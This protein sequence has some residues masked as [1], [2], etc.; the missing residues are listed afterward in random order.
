MKKDKI[1]IIPPDER[2]IKLIEQT[3]VMIETQQRL[4]ETLSQ[5]VRLCRG[6]R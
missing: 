3:G 5:P 4:I 1:E 6:I 2:I